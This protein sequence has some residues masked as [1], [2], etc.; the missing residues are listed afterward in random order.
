MV[1]A[2]THPHIRCN[3]QYIFM[4]LVKPLPLPVFMG[5]KLDIF[6]GSEPT[7]HS[8]ILVQIIDHGPPHIQI[9]GITSRLDKRQ[10]SHT[11]THTHG[12]C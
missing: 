10:D 4:L 9:V 11:H 12:D 5:V 7:R 8:G 2:Y 3:E 6:D 1:T